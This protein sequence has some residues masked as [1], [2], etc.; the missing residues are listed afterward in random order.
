[1]RLFL[2][3]LRTEQLTFWRSRESAI[4][5]FVFPPMLFLLL[6]AVYGGDTVE[7]RPAV[8]YLLAGLLGY[9]VANTALGGL[10]ITLVIR[11]EYGI[12]KRLRSTPLPAA[13]YLAAVL[14]SS[15]LVFALQAAT[16]VTL[17]LAAYDADLPRSPPHVVLALLLGGV[18]FAGLGLGA[19]ALIRSAES[20]AAVV[21][22][23]VLPMA[24]LSGSFG[25]TDRYP[26]VLRAA[27]DVLPLRYFIDVVTGTYLDGDAIWDDP[28]A[29]AVLA[30]WGA[31]GYLVAWRR[32]RWEPR[33]R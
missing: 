3:Q 1:M 9:A 29:L 33:E 22:V 15:L 31:A 27:A 19:T 14:A 4:F 10:A 28:L 32:F 20:V 8:D 24:F 11:R 5:V 17:G 25:S 23:V 2:H 30:A 16:V 18:A 6:G 26:S 21:N 13:T 7:G 12:L